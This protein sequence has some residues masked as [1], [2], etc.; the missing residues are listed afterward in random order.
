M[1]LIRNKTF[2]KLL[3]N[4]K[5]CLVFFSGKKRSKSVIW[6]KDCDFQKTTCFEWH[7]MGQ[8]VFT[9]IFSK[10]WRNACL[11]ISWIET[12]YLGTEPHF[13]KDL[14]QTTGQT[15]KKSY[16]KLREKKHLEYLLCHLVLKRSQTPPWFTTF[17]VGHFFLPL[18][19]WERFCELL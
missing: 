10:F 6:V 17:L 3:H 13:F 4:C 11:Q 18:N 8:L 9:L 14:R 7:R 5:C 16:R 12:L 2:T 15:N 1:C 19:R